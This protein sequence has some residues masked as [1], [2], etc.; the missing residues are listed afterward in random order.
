[1][2]DCGDIGSNHDQDGAK[3]PDLRF[4]NMFSQLPSAESLWS[5]YDCWRRLLCLLAGPLIVRRARKNFLSGNILRQTC[6]WITWKERCPTG[7]KASATRTCEQNW[8]S[9]GFGFV[10]EYSRRVDTINYRVQTQCRFFQFDLRAGFGVWN[11]W[12]IHWTHTKPH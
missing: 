2:L 6:G 9:Y 8:H 1:M 7:R 4:S 3:A 12:A 10:L 11:S 5:G